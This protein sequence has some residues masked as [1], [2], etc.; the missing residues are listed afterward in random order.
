MLKFKEIS[1][2]IMKIDIVALIATIVIYTGLLTLTGGFVVLIIRSIGM[3][4]SGAYFTGIGL[5]IAV[6]VLIVLFID[7]TIAYYKG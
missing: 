5:F 7:A 1:S 2:N 3:V 4:L 6:T